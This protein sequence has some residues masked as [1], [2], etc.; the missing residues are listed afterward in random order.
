ME[1]QD[2]TV[3]LPPIG[4]ARVDRDASK[5]DPV[6]RCHAIGYPWFA[7]TPSPDAVRE[8]VDAIGMIPV[9]SNLAGGLLS[10]EVSP[11]PQ[12]RE[13]PPQRVSLG[14]S[15]WSGMSGAPVLADGLLLGVVTVHA[16]RAG[17]SSIT[18]VPVTALEPDPDHP[19]WGP[20]SRIPPH[21]G[22]G[23]AS[24]ASTI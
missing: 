6:E 4:L 8:T 23:W 19:G 20:G 16:P 14:K 11:K 10:V 22:H 5:A 21:G 9:L 18:A 12:E 13:L 1:I 17:P 15:E 2:E 24:E 7:E 3:D